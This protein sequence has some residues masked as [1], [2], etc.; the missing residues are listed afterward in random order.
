MK[1]CPWSERGKRKGASLST[2]GLTYRT[3]FGGISLVHMKAIQINQWTDEL[4]I[5]ADQLL[6]LFFW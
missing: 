6:L 1:S 2:N 4:L 3:Y 5:V